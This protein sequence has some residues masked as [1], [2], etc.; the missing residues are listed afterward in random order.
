MRIAAPTLK[1]AKDIVSDNLGPITLDAPEGLITPMKSEYR[2]QVGQSELRLGV[3]ERANVDSLRGGNAK[4]VIC[5]E[6][7][8][9]TSDD[10]EYALQNH[11]EHLRHGIL[12]R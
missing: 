12:I 1:Q 8:F 6:G 4:L 5:E 10:Y 7:G 9:V 11:N 2:W 3:L